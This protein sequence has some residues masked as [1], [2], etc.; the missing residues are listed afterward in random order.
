MSSWKTI[1]VRSNGMLA[2]SLALGMLIFEPAPV[3]AQSI[4]V[5]STSTLAATMP[6]SEAG[7]P[8]TLQQAIQITLEKNPLRK[9]AVADQKAASAGVKRARSMMLPQVAFSETATRGNDP[10]YVFGTKLRQQRFTVADFALNE[11]NTPAPVSNFSSR[12][13]GEWSLFD[14]FASWRNLSRTRFMQQAS[15]EQLERTDQELVLRA[16]QAYY[17]VLL[18]EKDLEVAEQSSATA[19]SLLQDAKNRYESGLVVESDFLSAQVNAASRQQELIR[20]Q[21]GVSLAQAELGTVL[22]MTTETA[23]KPVEAL[24]ETSLQTP[25]LSELESTA[26]NTRP[27]L[28]RIRAEEAAQEQSVSMAKSSFGPKLN[29]YGSWETDSQNPFSN[30]ANNWVGGIEL[31]LDLF[32]GGAKRANLL[33]QQAMHEHVTAGKQAYENQVRLEVRRAYYNFQSSSQQVGVARAATAQAKES[34]RISQDRYDSGLATMTDLLQIQQAMTQAQTNYWN[35]VY[36]SRTSYAT[37][38]LA[39]GTLNSQSLV[40]P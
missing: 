28:K 10:V 35:A 1:I 31:K 7:A 21:N 19:Q 25:P 4:S 24:T 38:Q 14:S 11:L 3:A 27:D 39:S 6:V 30:A 20:A 2:L 37:L 5:E 16:V 9:A 36:Q 8:I 17:G 23:Y 32:N 29:A 33:Q 13:A 34:L 12:F 40:T 26:L 15:T 22:G 18:A